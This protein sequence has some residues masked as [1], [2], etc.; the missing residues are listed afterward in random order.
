MHYKITEHYARGEEKPIAEFRDLNDARIFMAI[1]VT[2]TELEKHHIIYRI[3]DDSELLDII[4][5]ENIATGYAKYAEGNSDL[6]IVPFIF[7]VMRNIGDTEEK[8][9]IASF[10]DKNDAHLFI[11]NKCEAD[12]TVNDNDLFFILKD[13]N[14]IDTSNRTI[15]AARKKE[16]AKGSEKGAASKSSPLQPRPKPPGSPPD[17]WSEE[18]SDE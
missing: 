11:F 14:L 17:F 2:E 1:K 8:T 13:Q 9:G 3:Y 10:N 5:P 15:N 16:C 4:N 7:N 6:N 12:N 18:D